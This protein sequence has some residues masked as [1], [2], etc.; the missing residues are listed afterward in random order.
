[1]AYFR[2]CV[3]ESLARLVEIVTG[4]PRATV[5]A[6]SV[7]VD[8]RGIVSSAKVPDDVISKK[9]PSGSDP[10]VQRPER[11]TDFVPSALWATVRTCRCSSF[12]VVLA[13]HG[14]VY[15]MDVVTPA[16]VV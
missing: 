7:G 11:V 2:V 5:E 12:L 6:E 3:K 4:L 10:A 8:A 1:M 13:A 15:L 14:A 9:D 16:I